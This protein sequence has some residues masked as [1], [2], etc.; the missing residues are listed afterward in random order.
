MRIKVGTKNDFIKAFRKGS[1]EAE[2]E[3][4]GHPIQHKKIHRNKKLYNRKT[5]HKLNDDN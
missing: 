5:K 1:R 4:Y 2:I 3:L